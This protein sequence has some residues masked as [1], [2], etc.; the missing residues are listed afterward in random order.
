MSLDEVLQQAKINKEG[1]KAEPDYKLF[2]DNI[3]YP[4]IIMN[5]KLEEDRMGI[6]VNFLVY[7]T[8]DGSPYEYRFGLKGGAE[9]YFREFCTVLGVTSYKSLPSKMLSLHFENNE[10]HMNVKADA[11][12]SEDDLRTYL[13]DMGSRKASQQRSTKK[14][15]M[16]KKSTQKTVQENRY[17]PSEDDF[18][19]L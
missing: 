9:Y 2:E 7:N 3:E 16:K 10:G 8:E 19:D 5:A 12:I 18:D 13:E 4:A 15:K 6:W 17:E 14:K 11:E 1:C